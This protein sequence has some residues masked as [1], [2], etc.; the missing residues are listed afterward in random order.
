MTLEQGT[1][2]PPEIADI[3]NDGNDELNFSSRMDT[4]SL[5]QERIKFFNILT[6][7]IFISGMVKYL[8]Y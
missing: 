8:S 3:D 7:R 5:A 1:R 4:F 6:Q 2:L